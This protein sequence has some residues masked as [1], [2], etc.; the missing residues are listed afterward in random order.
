MNRPNELLLH[1]A[2][3]FCEHESS[4]SQWSCHMLPNFQRLTV[5]ST[6]VLCVAQM[7]QFYYSPG[8][9]YIHSLFRITEATILYSRKM[10]K[11][12]NRQLNHKCKY[13]I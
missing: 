4:A 12:F 3:S 9:V 6:V 13:T 10:V 5:D 8:L 1:Q 7:L 2:V 11:I